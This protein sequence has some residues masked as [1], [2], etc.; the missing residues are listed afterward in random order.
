[1]KTAVSLPDDLFASADELAR[2]L[3]VSRSEFCARAVEEYV[4]KHR[5]EDVT[6]PLNQVYA[7]ED[8][9]LDSDLVRAQT[10]LLRDVEW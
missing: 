10:T 7:R 1:M 8:G 3:G 4:A 9:A 2:R 5:G 6:A